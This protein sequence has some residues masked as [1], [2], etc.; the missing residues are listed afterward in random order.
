MLT[1]DT[2]TGAPVEVLSHSSPANTVS[3][4]AWS[5]YAEANS[6]I[7]PAF[8]VPNWP[9]VITTAKKAAKA[10]MPL[11]LVGWDIAVTPAGVTVLEGNFRS[12]PFPSGTLKKSLA[13][14]FEAVA[15][16]A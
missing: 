3:H 5:S 8:A 7:D 12:D 11:R 15:R 13:P 2:A 16:L 9:D 1:L 4:H 14:A 6:G 10:F